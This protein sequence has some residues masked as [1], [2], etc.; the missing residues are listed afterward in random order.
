MTHD[1]HDRFHEHF[2]RH[3][4]RRRRRGYR[5]GSGRGR[6]RRLDWRGDSIE[7]LEEYQRD[8]EQRV[9]DVAERIRSLRARQDTETSS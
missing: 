2:H 5:N 1:L 8:L 7:A 6:A 3:R 9:A 4:G